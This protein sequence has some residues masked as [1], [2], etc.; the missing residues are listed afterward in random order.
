[1]AHTRLRGEGSLH[2]EHHGAPAMDLQFDNILPG[3][4][5]WPREHQDQR[6]I[7]QASVSRIV[8]GAQCCPA[9]QGQ[10]S[11]DCLRNREGFRAA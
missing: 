9:R 7:E 2:R 11:S 8:K 10:W 4:S 1:M 5:P 6:T 3:R